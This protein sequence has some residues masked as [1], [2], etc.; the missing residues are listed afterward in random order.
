MKREKMFVP[1]TKQKEIIL[2]KE[3][4]NNYNLIVICFYEIYF[5]LVTEINRIAGCKILTLRNY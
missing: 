4:L 2:S 1:E 5:N 3:Y